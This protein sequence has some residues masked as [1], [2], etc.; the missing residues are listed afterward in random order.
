MIYCLE[1]LA[2]YFGIKP[3]EFWN[4]TYREMYLYCEMQFIKNTESFKQ[5]V[6]LQEAVTNKMIQA[7]SMNK[8]PKVVPLQKVFKEL[9]KKQK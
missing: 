2:Y 8:K 7:D 6:I 4:S 9:F 1:P 5:E 3:K